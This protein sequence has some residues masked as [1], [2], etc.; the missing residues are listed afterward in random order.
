MAGIYDFADAYTN[1]DRLGKIFIK[2]GHGGSPDERPEVYAVSNTLA[3][4]QNVET[5]VL[6]MHGEADVR[7]PY[8][9][10]QLATEILA[11]E[12]KIFEARSYPG[13]PHGFRNPM[14]RIDMYQR[15]EAWFDLWVKGTVDSG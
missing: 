5:P 2:T 11:R 9:Q 15:L 8:R 13:E 7:A 1:A 14:N 6:T 3:R 10:F 4:I 12:G